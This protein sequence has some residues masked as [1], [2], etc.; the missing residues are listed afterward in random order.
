MKSSS[1]CPF[2]HES[3]RSLPTPGSRGNIHIYGYI[4]MVREIP[5]S[6]PYNQLSTCPIDNS[7]RLACLAVTMHL[8]WNHS[9]FAVVLL[10]TQTVYLLW[11]AQQLPLTP[12]GDL[13]G[14]TRIHSVVVHNGY[15]CLP[16]GPGNGMETAASPPLY[17]P[18]P[19]TGNYHESLPP[20]LGQVLGIGGLPSQHQPV[21]YS[22]H[23]FWVF[24]T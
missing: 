6:F 15:D 13:S 12:G 24:P 4:Y 9:L 16:V 10:T 20:A 21:G 3:C 17:S 5:M 11:S 18:V 19:S 8:P 2:G 14:M 23:L 7:K 1:Q 22:S